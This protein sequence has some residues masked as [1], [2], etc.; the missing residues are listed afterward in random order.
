M[1]SEQPR[2]APAV[3]SPPGGVET[4]DMLEVHK[5][6]RRKFG[7]TRAY[8][9]R[10]RRRGPCPGGDDR[11]TLRAVDVVPRHPPHRGRPPAV[12]EAA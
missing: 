11:R 3:G 9:R 7:L 4:R 8:I 6:I 1:N 12:A 10:V 5:V 2:G